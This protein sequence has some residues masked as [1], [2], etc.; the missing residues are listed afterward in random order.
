MNVVTPNP[1]PLPQNILI[2]NIQFL[3]VFNKIRLL[4]KATTHKPQQTLGINIAFAH[5]KLTAGN[6]GSQ[7]SV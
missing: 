6:V 1:P 5:T 2:F 4:T 7:G 3:T